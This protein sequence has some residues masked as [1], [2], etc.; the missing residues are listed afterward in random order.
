MHF[1]NNKNLPNLLNRP[2]T[3]ADHKLHPKRSFFHLPYSEKREKNHSFAELFFNS[4]FELPLQCCSSVKREQTE[5]IV[6]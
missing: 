5:I 1:K 2:G 6:D 3:L 4:V